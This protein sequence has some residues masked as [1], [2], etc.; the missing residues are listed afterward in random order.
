MGGLSWTGPRSFI[1]WPICLQ[2]T[3]TVLVNV[4]YRLTLDARKTTQW[5]ARSRRCSGRVTVAVWDDDHVPSSLLFATKLSGLALL[6]SHFPTQLE[7]SKR[8]ERFT[9]DSVCNLLGVWVAMCTGGL[10]LGASHRLHPALGDLVRCVE[11]PTEVVEGSMIVRKSWGAACR[12]VA[13]CD[14]RERHCES[15]QGVGT[16]GLASASSRW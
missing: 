13:T 8:V 6:V 7:L 16:A 14:Q 2:T 4:P 15:M 11:H 3:V 5:V 1:S 10:G 9:R 12:E